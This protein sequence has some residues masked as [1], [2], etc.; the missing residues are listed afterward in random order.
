MKKDITELFVFIDNF[1]LDYDQFIQHHTLPSQRK[2]TRRPGL[3]MSEVMTIILLF[4]QSPAKNF[5]FFYHSY[6][7]MYHSD[8]PG[9]PGYNRF[10][11]LQQRCLKKI[12]KSA[13][14]VIDLSSMDS[15][16]SSQP[17]SHTFL[18]TINQPSK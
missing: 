1:C 9:L 18:K 15:Y 14:H 16:T 6:L 3:Q 12:S 4:H 17:S 5:K 13:T 11:E 2:P 8:F 7:Q 10:L